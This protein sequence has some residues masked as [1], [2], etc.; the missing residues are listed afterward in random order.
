MAPPNIVAD[1]TKPNGF[2]KELEMGMS[3]IICHSDND[4]YN[5]VKNDIELLLGADGEF[6]TD[7]ETIDF[8][9]GRYGDR[10]DSPD[11]IIGRARRDY[12]K[13]VVILTNYKIEADGPSIV[14]RLGRKIK[15]IYHNY[16][17]KSIDATRACLELGVKV[18]EK[19]LLTLK[20]LVPTFPDEDI[21][22]SLLRN[23]ATIKRDDFEAIYG[24]MANRGKNEN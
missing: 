8:V 20:T 14:S 5:T 9:A 1:H 18:N 7:S 23:G 11:G 2:T 16:R 3:C 10:L 22:I 24:E 17:Y 6:F 12:S 15:E 4:G 21:L 13:S 19:S